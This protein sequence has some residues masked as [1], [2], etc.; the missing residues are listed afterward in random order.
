[1]RFAG[2]AVADRDDILAA[3]DV[4]AVGQLQHQ[5]LVE[6]GDRGEVETVE[7]FH[8]RE[9]CLLDAALDHPAFPL[10]QFEL[11]QAQQI[12]GMIA[13][14]GGACW[15]SLSY[16]RKKVGSLSALR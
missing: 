6:R 5:C 11:G 9:P 3:S 7:A 2:A 8:C 1:M 10:N 15:A 4:L 16:S 12:A 14:L 13:P